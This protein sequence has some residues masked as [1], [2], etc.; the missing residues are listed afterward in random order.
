MTGFL[1][2]SALPAPQGRSCLE[3]ASD[4]RLDYQRG[5]GL[6]LS[7]S[8]IS[9]WSRRPA[10]IQRVLHQSGPLSLDFQF[11]ICF[12]GAGPGG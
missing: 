12:S 10:L 11:S 2:S 6:A 3:Q 1:D 8:F 4:E 7:L 5:N 9:L